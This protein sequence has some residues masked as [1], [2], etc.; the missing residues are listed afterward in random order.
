MYWGGEGAGAEAGWEGALRSLIKAGLWS[1][2]K[3]RRWYSRHELCDLAGEEKEI[4]LTF[5]TESEKGDLKLAVYLS[6][7]FQ[8]LSRE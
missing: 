4:P 8:L 6:G 2:G 5:L 7:L 1:R 3:S